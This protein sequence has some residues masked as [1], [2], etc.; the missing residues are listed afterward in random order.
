MGHYAFWKWFIN[1]ILPIF[2]IFTRN[3]SGCNGCSDWSLTA[4]DLM[5]WESVYTAMKEILDEEY[6]GW[7]HRS[8][9]VWAWE[10]DKEN[11][12][13]SFNRELFW[14]DGLDD[15]EMNDVLT[16]IEDKTRDNFFTFFESS[17][18][19]RDEFG[20]VRR[21]NDHDIPNRELQGG[22]YPGSRG[23]CEYLERIQNRLENDHPA[24]LNT[25]PQEGYYDSSE[26]RARAFS[27]FQAI[28]TWWTASGLK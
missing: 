8:G 14:I 22:F 3:Q 16:R 21:W 23:E 2:C 4:A 13:M 1:Q 20:Y 6:G 17:R 11:R 7:E 18:H 15:A 28:H 12:T 26:G 9:M 5:D 24:M 19:C 27:D 10:I 25:S